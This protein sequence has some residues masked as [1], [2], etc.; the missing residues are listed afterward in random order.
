[1]GFNSSFNLAHDGF[2]YNFSSWFAKT[3]ESQF[4]RC[5]RK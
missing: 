2:V 5:F 1:M 4:V 3:D